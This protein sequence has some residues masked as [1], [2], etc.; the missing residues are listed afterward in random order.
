MDLSVAIVNW[1]TREMLRECLGSLLQHL[2]DVEYEVFVVDNG[3]TDG[4]VEMVAEYFPTVQVIRNE[5]NKGFACANNQA[6]RASSGRYVLLLNSDAFVQDNSLQKMVAILDA[7]PQI[8]IAGARL[9][10]PDGSFQVSHGPLPS[11]NAER[12]S[13]LGLDRLLRKR[14]P[15]NSDTGFIETGTVEGACLIARREALDQFGLIDEDFFFFS[16]EVDLCYRAHKN[17]WKVV[18]IP[19][20]CVVH[21]AGGSTGIIPRRIVLLY[22]GKLQYFEKHFGIKARKKLYN[23]MRLAT[24]LKVLAYSALRIISF[25]RIHKDSLWR[26]VSKGLAELREQ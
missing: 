26:E 13:L 5:E 11:L 17:G 8:A 24:K 9:V 16:E 14:Q 4:S 19:G 3:S 22:R 7:N 1:N 15:I 20:T 23:A 6:I 10:Y 25:G 2:S 18:N 12:L 21:V